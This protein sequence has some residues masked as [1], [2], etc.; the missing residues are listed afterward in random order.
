M[1][2][3]PTPTHA[4]SAPAMPYCTRR[5]AEYTFRDKRQGNIAAFWITLTRYAPGWRRI[6]WPSAKATGDQGVSTMVF[7]EADGTFMSRGQLAAPITAFYT[8]SS[9]AT[10]TIAGAPLASWAPCQPGWPRKPI[11]QISTSDQPG[12]AGGR[13][14][15]APARHRWRNLVRLCQRSPLASVPTAGRRR[16]RTDPWPSLPGRRSSLPGGLD[17]QSLA[18]SFAAAGLSAG[19]P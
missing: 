2:A 18:E 13:A 7:A 1:I 11:H 17:K 5:I 15:K 16:A 14:V 12:D 6:A 3:S 9:G 4:E 19:G 8:V 10:R